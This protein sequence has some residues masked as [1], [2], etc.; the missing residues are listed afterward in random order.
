MDLHTATLAHL[1]GRFSPYPQDVYD[2][3]VENPRV[4][5]TGR[6][7]P[8]VIVWLAPGTDPQAPLAGP[9]GRE[10]RLHVTAAGM[11]Q[12]RAAWAVD[13]VTGLLDGALLTVRGVPV[14]VGWLAGYVPPP[15]SEDRDV[16][17][18]R[19]FCPL[20]FTATTG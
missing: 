6:I 1:R 19:W 3:T 13:R 11:D 5:G 9:T 20:I 10:D 14:E 8:Y 18:V 2:G 17:P 4:D 12:A 7:Q 15:I 16:S